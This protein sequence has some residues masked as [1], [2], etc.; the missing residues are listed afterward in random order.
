M[1]FFTKGEACS[2]P[3]KACGVFRWCTSPYLGILLGLAI[4]IHGSTIFAQTRSLANQYS[5]KGGVSYSTSFIRITRLSDNAEADLISDSDF[6]P[7]LSLGSP[8]WFLFSSGLSAGI[9]ASYS[10]FK[11]SRQDFPASGPAS[12][13]NTAEG[14]ML[15]ITPALSYFLGKDSASQ[16][17]RI[18][19][20]IGWAFA[21]VD[22]RV[23]FGNKPG[24]EPPEDLLTPP[25]AN[26]AV[27]MSIEY[28]LGPISMAVYSGGPLIE[29]RQHEIQMGNDAF[30][31]S[32]VYGFGSG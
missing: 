11:A 23:E 25:G 14:R 7:Y 4:L 10:Q 17:L 28:R 13:G 15:I 26:N 1:P 6:S 29:T 27:T 21:T 30:V 2:S 16:F 9:T 8:P 19:A 5:L 24:Q 31:L 20:G 3:R 22:G 32:Y 18:T 12:A